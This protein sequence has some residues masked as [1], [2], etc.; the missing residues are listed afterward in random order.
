[1]RDQATTWEVTALEADK[2]PHR[3]AIRLGTLSWLPRSRGSKNMANTSQHISKTGINKTYCY[4]STYTQGSYMCTNLDLTHH[5]YSTNVFRIG[6][7]V[8]TQD[9]AS[10]RELAVLRSQHGFLQFVV[11]SDMLYSPTIESNAI[12]F[13]LYRVGCC[14]RFGLVQSMWSA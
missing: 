14:C 9:K 12:F 13:S 11:V 2:G 1:M 7:W 10:P 8:P 5:R 4:Y 3:K 6:T